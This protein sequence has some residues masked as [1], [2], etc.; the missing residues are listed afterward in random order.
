MKDKYS[1]HEDEEKILDDLREWSFQYFNQV[2]VF[3]AETNVPTQKKVD[4]NDQIYFKNFDIHGKIVFSKK[5]TE[6]VQVE[7]LEDDRLSKPE[8]ENQDFLYVVVQDIHGLN[9]ESKIPVSRFR[10]F[11]DYVLPLQ[12]E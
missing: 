4:I 2:Y 10:G 7:E 11:Y 3:E 6:Q 8:F 5:K 1:Y 12:I 9:F